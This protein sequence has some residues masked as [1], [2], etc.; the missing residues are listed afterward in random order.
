LQPSLSHIILSDLD[1]KGVFV[2][3][4]INSLDG[5]NNL[6]EEVLLYLLKSCSLS[7]KIRIGGDVTA[8]VA[9][10]II[11]S[12]SKLVLKG[13]KQILDSSNKTLE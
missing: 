1:S 8:L 9:S 7:V 5:G 13:S 12:N 2:G 10:T 11:F 4:V 6:V 3:R